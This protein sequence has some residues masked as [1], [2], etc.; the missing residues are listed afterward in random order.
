M[1]QQRSL[2]NNKGIFD[3]LDIAEGLKELLTT[4]GFTLELLQS[5]G[6]NQMIWHE[7]LVLMNT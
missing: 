2:T 3:E 1:R 6:V 5:T 4:H 7:Y